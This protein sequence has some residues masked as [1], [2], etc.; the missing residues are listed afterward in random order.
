ME[1]RRMLADSHSQDS[2]ASRVSWF[3]MGEINTRERRTLI[4]QSTTPDSEEQPKEKTHK[5]LNLWVSISQLMRLP[6]HYV[7]RQYSPL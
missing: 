7:K 2:R 4:I 5:F 3:A 6:T 1:P